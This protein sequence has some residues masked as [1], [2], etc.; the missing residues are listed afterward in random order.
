[1]PPVAVPAGQNLRVAP[2]YSVDPVPELNHEAANQ[3]KEVSA[4][5]AET[6]CC[7]PGYL[8]KRSG[9]WPQYNAMRD[10]TGGEHAPE[11][12]EQLAGEGHDHLRFACTAGPLGPRAEPLGQRAVLLKQQEPPSELDHAGTYAGIARLG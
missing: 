7:W 9:G 11:G 12:D 8:V 5:L 3:A 2:L 1:M 6:L 10:F 4:W